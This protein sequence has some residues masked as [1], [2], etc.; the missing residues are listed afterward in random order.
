MRGKHGLGCIFTKECSVGRHTHTAYNIASDHTYI[1]IVNV[2]CKYT[3]F[4]KSRFQTRPGH[5][6]GRSWGSTA[7][8]RQR[9]SGGGGR[10]APG[11]SQISLSWQSLEPPARA[12]G[13]GGVGGHWKWTFTHSAAWGKCYLLAGT[14]QSRVP[15]HSGQQPPHPGPPS[16]PG[17]NTPACLVAGMPVP[18]QAGGPSALATPAT[19]TTVFP[20]APLPRGLLLPGRER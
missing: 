14:P 6:G 19:P 12:S 7:P 16:G 2:S 18:A 13:R 17:L 10:Q 9:T 4:G 3:G 15:H 20:A 8:C 11:N 5:A 1:V